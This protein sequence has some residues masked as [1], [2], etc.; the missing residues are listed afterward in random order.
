MTWILAGVSAA[1]GLAA[2][3]VTVFAYSSKS[4]ADRETDR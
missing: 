1:M 4:Q 2:V 3:I